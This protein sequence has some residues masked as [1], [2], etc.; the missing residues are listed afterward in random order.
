MSIRPVIGVATQTLAAIPGKLPDCWVMGQTY[1][2]VLA[3]LGAYPLLVPLLPQDEATLDGIYRLLDGVFL[4]GGVDMDPASYG[5]VRHER[6]DV[7]DPARDWTEMQLIRW[8][9]R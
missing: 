4:T 9:L 5:E 6:C 2:R 8:A 7:P 3:Q 1:V